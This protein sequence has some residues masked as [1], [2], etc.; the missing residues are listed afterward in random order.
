[1][2]FPVR[3]HILRLKTHGQLEIKLNRT[4]LPGSSQGILQM[5]I[6]LGSVESAV[7]LIH[8]I[9][10]PDFLQSLAQPLC[11]KLPVL[12]AADAV[13]RTCGKLYVIDKA[14][15][16]VY[17]INQPHNALDFIRNLLLRH[18]NMGIILRKAAD[19]HQAMELP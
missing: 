11:C 12:V 13:F 19:T 7:P 1:M 10:H 18:K 15:F 14:E 6:D 16:T 17:L 9:F 2:L 8:H 4:T 5:E 3:P